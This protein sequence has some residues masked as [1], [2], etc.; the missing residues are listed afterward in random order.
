VG[1]LEC[2]E[3]EEPQAMRYRAHLARPC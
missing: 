2:K 1:L 3:L